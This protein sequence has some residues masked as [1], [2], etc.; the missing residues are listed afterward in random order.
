MREVQVEQR[1]RGAGKVGCPSSK[2]SCE[3]ADAGWKQYLEAAPPPK[4]GP[5][6]QIDRKAVCRA[7]Y[8]RSRRDNQR[9]NP[10]ALIRAR[11]RAGGRK[12]TSNRF[13]RYLYRLVAEIEPAIFVNTLQKYHRLCRLRACRRLREFFQNRDGAT[14]DFNPR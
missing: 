2:R 6:N 10:T 9:S 5:T 14:G 1:G 3:L 12:T 13:G 4:G 7:T 11:V 8:R